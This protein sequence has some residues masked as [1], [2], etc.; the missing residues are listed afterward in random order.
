VSGADA[1]APS[2]T[3]PDYETRREPCKHI[4]AVRIVIQRELEFDGET[5]TEKVTETVTVTKTTKRTYPQNW[6]GLQ[7]GADQ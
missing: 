5:V 7:R 1:E 3:C 2:C 4:Y 6:P